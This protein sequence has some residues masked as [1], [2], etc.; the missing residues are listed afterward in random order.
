MTPRV[1]FYLNTKLIDDARSF[2]YLDSCFRKDESL[3]DDVDKQ[4]GYRLRSSI[5]KGHPAL[6]EYKFCRE[7]KFVPKSDA[8]QAEA[9][10]L[11]LKS[12]G[13][14]QTCSQGSE[15]SELMRNM[16]L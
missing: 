13:P 3:Q 2:E 14:K 16:L 1:N 12:T 7:D 11:V 8:S 5:G 9:D 4:G 10:K 15:V 6:S